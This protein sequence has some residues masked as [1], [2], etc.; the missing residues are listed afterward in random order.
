M[1]LFVTYRLYG[2]PYVKEFTN[3]VKAVSFAEWANG[4]VFFEKEGVKYPDEK[5]KEIKKDRH[6]LEK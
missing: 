3:F 4:K 5:E 6:L 2:K 1:T